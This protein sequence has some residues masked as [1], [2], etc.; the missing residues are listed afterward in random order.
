MDP[1]QH[2]MHYSQDDV[3][4]FFISAEQILQ[5]E[6]ATGTGLMSVIGNLWWLIYMQLKDVL[7]WWQ[8]MQTIRILDHSQEQK[9][10]QQDIL[11]Q[12]GT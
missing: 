5:L 12:W 1:T 8:L 9:K 6:M 3:K 4:H 2:T 10:W 11:F 7:S